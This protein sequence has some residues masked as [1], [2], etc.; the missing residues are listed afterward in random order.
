MNKIINFKTALHEKN[1]LL[2]CE[3]YGII[4]YTVNG[5]QLIYY[6]NNAI[7]QGIY[8]TYKHTVNLDTMDETVTELKR[9]NKKGF[10]NR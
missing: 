2:F 7:A 6:R 4:E 1:A 3:K 8:K 9:I 10:I 5:N